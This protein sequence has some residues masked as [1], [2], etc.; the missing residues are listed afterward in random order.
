VCSRCAPRS[1][2]DIDVDSDDVRP[3][4]GKRTRDTRA[5]P[6]ADFEQSIAAGKFWDE[7][8]TRR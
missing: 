7:D 6:D 5:V 4:L 8:T 2:A 3:A 1:F